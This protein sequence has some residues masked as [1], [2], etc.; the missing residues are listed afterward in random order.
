MAVL[1]T[2]LLIARPAQAVDLELLAVL[3]D[4]AAWLPG[5]YSSAA[6]VDLESVR[7]APPSGPHQRQLRQIARIDAPQLGEY[8][9]VSQTRLGSRRSDPLAAVQPQLLVVA[10]DAK[11]RAVG[12]VGRRI[13]DAAKFENLG[14]RPDL[15]G[16][17]A[18]DPAYGANCTVLW[19]LHGRQLVG[20]V[21]D[22][23][24]EDS[25][26]MTARDGRRLRWQNEWVLN[27]DQLW[28][29]DNGYNADGSLFQ[30]RA[31]RAHLRLTRVRD[32]ERLSGQPN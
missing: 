30:G 14:S 20:R 5:E 10:I 2:V 24:T 11:R 29:D 27:P 26:T 15:W 32:D 8:V 4:L 12:M 9:F 6:Q 31:D 19:R 23:S 16:K 7:G 3:R 13:L 21:A 28:I 18:F 17:V 25:C 1:L 22:A